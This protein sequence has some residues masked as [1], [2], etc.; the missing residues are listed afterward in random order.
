MQIMYE[1]SLV[2]YQNTDKN[3]AINYIPNASSAG[4]SPQIKQSAC[5]PSVT[6]TYPQSKGGPLCFLS[7]FRNVQVISHF[8]TVEK[9]QE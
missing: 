9:Y 3:L 6:Y 2:E 8:L 4:K 1:K 7:C 5:L